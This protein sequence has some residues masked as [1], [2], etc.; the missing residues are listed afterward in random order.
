MMELQGCTV[1]RGAKCDASSLR[2]PSAVDQ[3]LYGMVVP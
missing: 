3:L 2:T 1:L